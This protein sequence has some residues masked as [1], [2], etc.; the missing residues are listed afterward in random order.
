MNTDTAA[1][2]NFGSDKLDYRNLGYLTMFVFGGEADILPPSPNVRFWTK[3]EKFG[4]WSSDGLSVYDP[5]RTF[6]EWNCCTAG[7]PYA[8]PGESWR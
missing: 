2:A 3:A 4:F 7:R 5:K 1:V 6:A 8:A